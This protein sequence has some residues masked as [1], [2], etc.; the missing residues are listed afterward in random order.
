M[1]IGAPGIQDDVDNNWT[2]HN[3]TKGAIYFYNKPQN[4]DTWTEIKDKDLANILT[5]I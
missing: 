3:I 4:S 1:I 5:Q 2:Y